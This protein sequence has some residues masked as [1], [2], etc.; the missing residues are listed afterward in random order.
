M[1]TNRDELLLIAFKLF[2]QQGYQQTTMTDLVR[3]SG[4]SKGAFHH[5]FARKGDLLEACLEHFF[6][7]FLPKPKAASCFT[8]LAL[9]AAHSYAELVLALRQQGIGLAAYQAFIWTLMPSHMEHFRHRQQQLAQQ[10]AQRF[11]EQALAGTSL[12]GEQAAL[13]LMALIEGRGCLLAL[14]EP[15]TEQEVIAAFVEP[16]SLLLASFPLRQL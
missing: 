10:L 7:R 15:T 12:T 3:A 4:L 9:S 5:Y 1:K 11:S 13:Q 14:A 2:L 8:E 6:N 16:V